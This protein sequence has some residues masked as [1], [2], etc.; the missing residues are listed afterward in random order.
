MTHFLHDLCCNPEPEASL[1]ALISKQII[2]GP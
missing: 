1:K 2:D